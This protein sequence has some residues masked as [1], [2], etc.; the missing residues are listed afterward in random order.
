MSAPIPGHEFI[1]LASAGAPL[2]SLLERLKEGEARRRQIDRE[3]ARLRD[4]EM[5]RGIDVA[6]IEDRLRDKLE[7]LARVAHA[8]RAAGSA[9]P[10]EASARE[11]DVHARAESGRRRS[12]LVHDRRRRSSRRGA[13]PSQDDQNR[14]RSTRGVAPTGFDSGVS[15]FRLPFEGLALRAAPVPGNQR[16]PA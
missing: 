8:G 6:A 4:A 1:Q 16:R 7:R 11:V 5:L 13:R 12:S 10:P 9:D 15:P 3:L 14:R 2:E